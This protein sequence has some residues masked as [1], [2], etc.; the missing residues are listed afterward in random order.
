MPSPDPLPFARGFRLF[1]AGLLFTA[2]AASAQLLPQNEYALLNQV[3]APAGHVA[4]VV[5]QPLIDVQSEVSP[6]TLADVNAFSAAAGP[7]W[8]FFVD[9]RSG[10]MAL[11]E[12][13]GLPWI[14]GRGNGLDPKANRGSGPGDVFTAGDLELKARALMAQYPNLFNVPDPQLVL[15]ARGTFN[16]GENGQFWNVSFNQV[17]GGVAVENARVLFRLSHGNLVQF[18]VDRAVPGLPQSKPVA[19]QLT[20][21]AAR[22]S[23]ISYIGGEQPGDTYIEDGA[24]RWVARGRGDTVGYTGPIGSGWNAELVYR[25]TFHRA[26]QTAEWQGLV[27]ANSGAI[28]RFID[29][30]AYASLAKASVYTLTNCSAPNTNCIGGDVN[31]VAVTMPF[32]KLTFTG[33]SCTGDACYTNS[34]GAFTYPPGAT[35]AA[36]SLDGKYIKIVDT[37]G[38]IAASATAPGN[39]DLG[40]SLDNLAHT[41]T[42]CQSATQQSPPGTGPVTGGSGDTHSAR[43][44]FYH[45][46]LINEKARSYMPNNQWL[47]GVDGNGGTGAAVLTTTD[48]APACNAFWSG[49]TGSLNFQQKTVALSCNN[50][51]ELPDVFLHEF[52]H[53]LDQNDATGTAPEGGTGEAMGDSFALLQGQHSC[54]GIGFRLQ[55]PTDV[56]WG[57]KAGY[58]N[59]T[60]GSSV[61]TCSGVRDLDY[62]RFC[63]RDATACLSAA[64]A[65]A[66][67]ADIVQGSHSGPSPDLSLPDAGTPAKYSTMD[68]TATPA[69]DGKSNFYNC[70]GPETTGCAGALN[71]GCHCESEIAS[72]SNWDLVKALIKTDFGGNIYAAPQGPKEVS[73][74]QYMDRLWYLT[75]DLAVS[76]YQAGAG[77]TNGCGVN[78]WFSNYRL[79]DDDNGNLSDGTPHA[80]GIFAAFKLHEIACGAAADPS[81]QTT[82]CPAIVAAPTLAACDNKAPVQISWNAV[83]GATQYRVLRNTLGCGFGFTPI[84]IKSGAQRFYEDTEVAPGN[85]YYYSVQPVGANAS[86]Y[87]QASNCV[88]VTPTTC[89]TTFTT[90]PTGV[91]LT[92]PGPNQINVAW[93]AVTGAGSYKIYRKPG[94]C[95]AATPYA[96]IGTTTTPTV[97]FLDAI[98][99]QGTQTY[100]YQVVATDNTC[101]SCASPPSTCVSAAATG[102]CGNSP[103]FAGVQSASNG[104][105]A[106][107]AITLR[108]NAGVASC[109]SGVLTYNVYR[110]T[111]VGFIP[112][113][114]NR[115]AS[116][117]SGTSFTNAYNVAY[118]AAYYYV[119]RAVDSFGN[120]DGNNVQVSGMASGPLTGSGTFS[121]TFEAPGGGPVNTGWVVDVI[122]SGAVN[123]WRTSNTQP[124]AG[125]YSAFDPDSTANSDHAYE[126]PLLSIGAGSVLSFWHTSSFENQ[127]D[128]ATCGTGFDG[129][130]VEY[131]VCAASPCTAAWTALLAVQISGK[132]YNGTIQS[133]DNNLNGSAGYVCGT[134]ALPAYAQST[135]NIGAIAGAG[136]V[137]VR[138]RQA[139]DTGN[140]GAAPVGWFLDDV[141]VTGVSN[142]QT[143]CTTAAC[144]AASMS[145]LTHAKSGN[146]LVESWSGVGGAATY[147]VYRGS[148]PNPATFTSPLAALFGGRPG[149]TDA[150][151]LATS[152][153]QF[154]DVT[155]VNECLAESPK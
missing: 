123:P 136:A 97:N 9:R 78:S 85:T 2:G 5:P 110:G 4:T 117:V 51:G 32:A 73:G 40:T 139:D 91:A 90:A 81:N 129:G 6:A 15:D 11:V 153:N 27:N 147:Y 68:T 75:R 8:R 134:G 140:T 98:G 101:A 121:E 23:L 95:A 93:N 155:F 39:I 102:A 65:A 33:G 131:R 83:S 105:T 49:G 64:A 24:L 109:G 148:A 46:N 89:T 47:K 12:G 127:T 67:D 31:E 87:G 50:T 60:T 99:L 44:C 151:Q 137:Q 71:H 41:N 25:F 106:N 120:E 94:D 3:Y 14:P 104:A 108:W 16:F 130:I 145:T 124:H 128:S 36:T 55:S 17:V 10:G 52:G 61:Q 66:R 126:S 57:N 28:S 63:A 7:G 92:T 79:V 82:G 86:C 35:A 149:Y 56:T 77:T 122:K 20:R 62:T 125:T 107:C 80:A 74:W 26:G 118:N 19:P 84:A 113:A 43:N 70:G 1:A 116:G 133:T 34:A 142:L 13:P 18:G 146:N 103:V 59:T 143:S 69:A 30:N 29:A 119:V 132:T 135:V 111:Q 88:T 114:G 76:A 48:I 72:Q 144:P 21:G 154:Y 96:A 141:Q 112:S 115:I 22:V 152:A 37:C 42:D 45:L 150:G 54:I 38:A 100:A 138:W 58:G 53:G